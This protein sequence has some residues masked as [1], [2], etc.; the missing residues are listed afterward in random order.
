[1]QNRTILAVDDT[2]E[3]LDVLVDLLS[4]YD[5]ID[6]TS[7]T[8]A[9]EI[10]KEEKID[11]ILLDIMMPQMDGFE[12]CR[13]L[14][15]DPMTKDI[16]VIFVTAKTDEESIEKAYDVGGS[17]YITKPFLPKELLARVKKEL[18]IIELIEKLNKQAT[19]DPLTG[20]YNRR[21]FMDS[22][23]KNIALAKRKKEPLSILMID[24]DHF[25]Q[26]NDTYGHAIGDEVIQKL[27]SIMQESQRKS[28]VIAR[29]GGEEFLIL[30]PDTP[31]ESAKEVAQKL[32]KKVE[33]SFVETHNDEKIRFSVSIG[34]A[35]INKEDSCQKLM[36]NADKAL[37]QAK[38]SG[39]NRVC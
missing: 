1:M 23:Q 6:A 18:R 28:D 26:I 25:K 5:V 38:E 31:Y 4:D 17:D 2:I 37:Y 30:L 29:Y 14:K 8:E 39:R 3:N 21:F 11:L 10:V 32:R 24:I 34:V 9:L 16:P 22:C 12:V 19:T 7:P 20:V 27:S 33:E 13:R 15:A 36:H 35:T